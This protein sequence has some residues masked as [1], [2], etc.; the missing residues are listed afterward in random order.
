[1]N[2]LEFIEYTAKRYGFDES[3]AETL[4]DMFVD[5]LQEIVA[6]C[7]EFNIDE[8]GIF[9]KM[10]LFPNGIKHKNNVSLKRTSVQNYVSFKA[11]DAFNSSMINN[12]VHV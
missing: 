4:I 5:T 12:E 11:N 3:L 1:M 7:Q 8:I 9:H 10:S 6:S 2:K